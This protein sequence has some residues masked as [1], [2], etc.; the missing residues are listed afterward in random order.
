MN[1]ICDN[2]LM[3]AFAETATTVE[4][5]H[6]SEAC[7][8]LCLLDHDMKQYASLVGTPQPVKD[9]NAEFEAS[10][11]PMPA[12]VPVRVVESYTAPKRSLLA[13][14]MAKRA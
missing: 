10:R 3:L 8:D 12:P 13:R 5:R 7:R 14:W 1:S 4:S 9:Y 6:V 2:A 11:A